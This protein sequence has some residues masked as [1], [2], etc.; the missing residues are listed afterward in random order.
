MD[1]ATFGKPIATI[2]GDAIRDGDE[3]AALSPLL[4]T[5]SE[6]SDV[7]LAGFAEQLAQVLFQRGGQVYAD[8]AGDS[9]NSDD[10]FLYARC[11]VVAL[12]RDHYERVV[13]SPS[14]MP[15]SLEE[16]CEGLRY[17]PQRAWA[18]LTGNQEEAWP[19]RTSVSDESGSNRALWPSEPPS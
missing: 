13:A 16:W 18:A 17:V 5:L 15:E 11:Y 12:G 1:R 4:Q 2:D 8:C 7:E 19:H 9:G 6:R 3:D 14:E 10:G